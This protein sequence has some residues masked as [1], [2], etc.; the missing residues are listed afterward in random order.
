MNSRTRIHYLLIVAAAVLAVSCGVG[1]ERRSYV[2]ERRWPA[3]AIRH[4]EVREIDG[5]LNV[6]AGATSEITLLARIR[7]RGVLPK[8]DK[9]NLCFFRTELGDDTLTIARDKRRRTHGFFFHVNDVTI[10]YILRVPPQVALDLNTV[11]G[12]I[13]TRGI[14]GQTQVTTV[15]GP[16]EVETTGANELSAKTINGHVRAKF[17]NTFQ[18]ARLKTVNGGVEAILPT[19][20][21]FVCDLSQVNGDF[22]ASFPLNIHSHPGS[23]RVSGEINGGRYELKIT[24]VNGDIELQNGGI[25]PVPPTAPIPPIPGAPHA[26]PVPP[27]PGVPPAP[28]APQ[29]PPQPPS[30]VL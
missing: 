4:L 16:I 13:S 12:R 22:E 17:L 30:T 1:G 21:S 9:E 2:V 5:S 11:N 27:A 19:G 6:E 15:N 3:A 20:A 7:T 18:G 10:D 24:T 28:P 14:D 26:Q 8:K 25:P 29:A 23:R